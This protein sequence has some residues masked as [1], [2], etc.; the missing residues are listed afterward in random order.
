MV[1]A[2]NRDSLIATWKDLLAKTG[3][4][5]QARLRRSDGEFRWHV[6]HV[7]PMRDGLGN[8]LKW[9]GLNVD[10]DHSRRAEPF[11]AHAQR[12]SSRWVASSVHLDTR[13][14]DWSEEVLPDL[15][16]QSS[17][18]GAV[19]RGGPRACPPLIDVHIFDAYAQQDLPNPGPFSFDLRILSLD[20]ETKHL[21]NRGL[22]IRNE[23]GVPI[24]IFGAL[25]DVTDR[26]RA[27]EALRASERLARGQLDAL[28]RVLDSLVRESNPDRFLE[29]VMM[30]IVRELGADSIQAWL[31]L[32]G[33][34]DF[35][36][37]S[38][39]RSPGA[40]PGRTVPAAGSAGGST[41]NGGAF[42][43]VRRPF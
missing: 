7:T 37:I 18:H 8:L 3:K 36:C 31:A 13:K 19:L 9:W 15:R 22:T 16:L 6:F 20:G 39:Y 10:V 11:L 23:L 25:M 1:H 29:H 43:M 41:P 42:S 33:S 24:E 35:E 38:D 5:V 32:D 28:T 40:A 12:V 27:A 26:V 34:L 30:T 14:V 4:C 2:D 21:T 17:D